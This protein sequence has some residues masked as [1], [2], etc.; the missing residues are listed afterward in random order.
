MTILLKQ[1]IQQHNT[2]KIN[3]Y[4]AAFAATAALASCGTTDTEPPT[5]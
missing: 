5:V 3:M 2:M 1:N 4:F